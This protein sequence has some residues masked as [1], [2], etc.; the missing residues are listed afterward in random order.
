MEEHS[1][2]YQQQYALY[3]TML[4]PDSS[5]ET[6]KKLGNEKFFQGQPA[7]AINGTF[8][9][10]S[11]D[12]Q[13]DSNKKKKKSNISNLKTESWSSINQSES[14]SDMVPLGFGRFQLSGHPISWADMGTSI[15]ALF[16]FCEGKIQDFDFIKCRTE[17][18]TISRVIKHYGEYG[19]YGSQ[20]PE[21]LF[22]GYGGY[23]SRL[24][25]LEVIVD[26]SKPEEVGGAPI[27]TSV[28]RGL[29]IPVPNENGDYIS[30]MATDNPVHI[31]RFILTDDKYG[32]IPPYR[33]ADARNLLTAQYCDELIEDRTQSEW[34]LLPTNEYEDYGSGYIRYRSTGVS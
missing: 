31:T 11:T 19:S 14:S 8:S 15:K 33:I 24:A 6:C 13:D 4:C 30:R 18:L 17:G 23:N 20:V 5:I 10:V 28:I 25:Y 2:L 27:V 3:G 26:G 21:V 32:K 16:G 7:V 22:N 29:E 1:Q 34:L 12:I 9:Y